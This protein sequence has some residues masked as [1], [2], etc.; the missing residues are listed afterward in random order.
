MKPGTLN[1]LYWIFTILFAAL[2]IFSA[3]G[4]IQPSA[5]AVKILHDG[6]GYPVYFI[7]FISI[8][9]LLGS[10]A[11]LIPGLVRV[12]EWA[13]AG[14]FF[15]LAGAAYSGV[16]AAGKFDPMMLTMLIWIIPGVLS[17]YYWHRKMGN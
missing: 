8:A 14:L 1:I 2:M 16:A 6:M 5:N 13:Y 4:G 11:I 7:Q 9:K 15:D 17:Y 12:K 10:I 3:V